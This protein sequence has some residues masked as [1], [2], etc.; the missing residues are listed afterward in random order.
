[1][2]GLV[3]ILKKTDDEATETVLNMLKVLSSEK[4]ASYGIASPYTTKTANSLQNLQG[5][6]L[7]SNIVIGHKFSNILTKDKKQPICLENASYVF[8]GRIFPKDSRISDA[9]VFA[10]KIPEKRIENTKR[11]IQK[12]EGD[13]AFVIAEPER[14]V[15]GRDPLGTRALYYGE[16]TAVAGIASERKALWAAG[17]KNVNSFPPGTVAEIN[18]H[19]FKFHF[20]KKITQ[21]PPRPLSMEKASAELLKLLKKAV[22]ERT[23]GLKRVAVSFS[24]G[25]DSSIVALLAK[26][27]GTDV[28]LIHVSIRNQAE[29]GHAEKA[30]AGLDLPIHTY[31]YTEEDVPKALPHVL[32]SIEESD[33]LKAS[34][35]IPFFWVAENADKLGY[36]VILAGQG[37]D[38]LFGG[39][40]RY[41]DQYIHEGHHK[42]SSTI[43]QDVIKLHENNLERD[44]KICNEKGLE[45]RLPFATVEMINF[46]LSLPLELKLEAKEDTLRKLV[47][48]Q[49][50]LSLGLPKSIVN[51]PKKAMQYAT[52]VSKA[53]NN[54]AKRNHQPL[55]TYLQTVFQ[56]V[57]PELTT[58]G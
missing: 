21:R 11:F 14:L 27:T 33:P 42:V 51:R 39:Y 6:N 31:T 30:A 25:L 20:I 1:M 43:F 47:L 16:N 37:S 32:R 7:S 24:G 56:T 38:E 3:A 58:H 19:G 55:Q 10:L 5:S 52:G 49:V 53:L 35:G 46:A 41:V 48:R 28:E 45:L 13:F 36:K 57:F 26:K 22:K 44:F 18:K 9:E 40:K 34:I 15:A 17:I 2:G 12:T 23:A 54:I 8:E 50:G 29:T 4:T